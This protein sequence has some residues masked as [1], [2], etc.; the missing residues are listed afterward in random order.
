MKFH[1]YTLSP[2]LM[3]CLLIAGCKKKDLIPV[4]KEHNE[5]LRLAYETDHIFPEGF[6]QEADP[7]SSTYYVN[8]VS[9]KPQPERK[10]E[11]IELH[12]DDERQA[13]T[14]VELS[15]ENSSGQT[16]PQGSSQTAKYFEY[17]ARTESGHIIRFRVHKSSYFEPT[18]DKFNP[19]HTIGRYKGVMDMPAVAELIQYLWVNYNM[20]LGGYQIAGNRVLETEGSVNDT[21]YTCRI[22]SLSITYGDW[23]LHDVIYVND[24]YFSLSKATGILQYEKNVEIAEIR[25]NYNGG[26][27]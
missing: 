22:R 3:A 11:W 15:R 14:W 25:G 12:T 13:L 8:T 19:D 9:I 6:Y 1:P 20:N 27:L 10:H 5:F 26:G 16:V 7:T 2:I 21:T 18:L 24:H 23:G 4:P 17:P